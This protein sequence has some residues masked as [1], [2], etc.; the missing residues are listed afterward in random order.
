MP[1]ATSTYRRDIDGLRAL[2]VL[3]VIAHH[4]APDLM[5][6]GFVGVDVFFVISGY[7]VT[8]IIEDDVQAGRFR[9]LDFI[10]K[11]CRRIVPALLALLT[12]TLVMGACVLTGPELVS[13]ARHVAAG[14]LS[15]SNL[16]LWSEVGYF[17]EAATLKPLLH[18]WSL[19][20]EEQFYLVW[21]LLLTILPLDR[22]VRAL[23]V[24]AVVLLSLLVSDTLAYDEP[25][26]A[27]YLLH[28]RAWELGAGG[29][30]ALVTPMV[31]DRVRV[32]EHLSMLR[33][34]ASLVGAALLTGAAF[35]MSS[36]TSWPGLAA[37]WPVLATMLLIAAGPRAW[38][39][40]TLLSARPA[41]W[42]GQRSYALY[43][44]HWPPLA[45]LHILAQE[46][47]WS[48]PV[49][50][51]TAL[52]LMLPVC[53]IADVTFRRIEQ[54]VRQRSTQIA[55]REAIRLRHLAPFGVALLTC[56]AVSLVVSRAHGFPSRYGTRAGV[57]A[58]LVL[59]AASADSITTYDRR[60]TRCRLADKG[61]ATWCWRIA[62]DGRGVAVIGDSH[63]EVVFAGLAE[64]QLGVPLFLTGRKGCAPIVQREP[65]A[66]RTAE[67]CRRATLL[68]HAAIRSDT[69]IT[70][71][72][73]VSRGPAYISGKGFGVDSLRPVVPVALGHTT[74][75]TLALRA[76][77]ALGL[78]RA[79]RSFVDAGKRV[80]LVT[81]VPEIGFLPTECVVGRPFGLRTI[82]TPCALPRAEFDARVSAYQS[83]VRQVA[84]RN[85]ALE[86][87]D[88][89]SLFC[90]DALCHADRHDRLLYQD[91]NH[92]TI[93]GSRI[94]ARALSSRLTPQ[95][96][97]QSPSDALRLSAQRV[98]GQPT[99]TRS[100]PVV[101]N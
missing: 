16:L 96:I 98:H 54:P 45:F 77:Y 74:D 10:W 30:L 62:G 83:L 4:V 82:R 48:E 18:L 58:S 94:I 75:D 25:A 66:E 7:L 40:G 90:D 97:V 44:W 69:T 73:I 28:S 68:A 47:A 56:V 95:R 20:I 49:Q 99:P 59:T 6:G 55:G 19:G 33:N 36:A 23:G 43:L 88:A 92:L 26:Q 22:R 41:Q 8:R 5:R 64:Q 46:E 42:V 21:P 85:P 87:F 70:T 39:N 35:G 84:T 100:S 57:D 80:V 51:V 72:L 24:G 1:Q 17:D 34:G 38:L 89:T 53:A 32:V 15:A 37:A 13:L 31:A 27:F 79:V 67:I 93:E 60:A 63:A 81:G 101:S 78:E 11:R 65:I 9:Y 76:A 52:L 14:S 91:G 3:I 12:S 2:A 29:L 71:V 86:V 61:T 50:Q